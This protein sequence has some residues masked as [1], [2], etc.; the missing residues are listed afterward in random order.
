MML[1][2]K[3]KFQQEVKFYNVNSTSQKYT[4]SNLRKKTQ[5]LINLQIGL[6]VLF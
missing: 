5:E 1:T 6:V 4:L 3:N 2:K